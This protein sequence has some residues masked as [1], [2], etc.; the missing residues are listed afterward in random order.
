LEDLRGRARLGCV[1]LVREQ[2]QG[3]S[4]CWCA[5]D[6]LKAGRAGE[7]RRARASREEAD[8]AGLAALG[9]WKTN[10]AGRMRGQRE[11]Q[12]GGAAW[13]KAGGA[14]LERAYVGRERS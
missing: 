11:Q 8:R 12:A 14:W 7:Q 10:A 13:G 5:C 2:G 3:R 4:G 9:S 1:F 6:E